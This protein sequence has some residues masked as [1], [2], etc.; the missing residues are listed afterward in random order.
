M[1]A[2]RADQNE[3]EVSEWFQQFKQN[4]SASYSIWDEKE[5]APLSCESKLSLF[6][7]PLMLTKSQARSLILQRLR[8]MN[9]ETEALHARL[10][11]QFHEPCSNLQLGP[12]VPK[13]SV[14]L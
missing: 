12:G 3:K 1:T 9:E 14:M 11:Q 2:A 4:K 10:S 13:K 5:G 6:L 8:I 7:N